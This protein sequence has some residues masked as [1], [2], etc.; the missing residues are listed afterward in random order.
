MSGRDSKA[1]I[2]LSDEE[3]SVLLAFKQEEPAS[4]DSIAQQ[5]GLPGE[6]VR[7]VLQMLI[8]KGLIEE[9]QL[10]EHEG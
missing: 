1:N 7:Q 8:A 10:P 6:A 9:S 4:I 3:K 2:E 5:A